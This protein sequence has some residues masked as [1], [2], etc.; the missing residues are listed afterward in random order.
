MFFGSLRANPSAVRQQAAAALGAGEGEAV[1]GSAIDRSVYDEFVL[2]L[3]NQ[4][5]LGGRAVFSE[6]PRVLIGRTVVT[7]QHN[8]VARGLYLFAME[9]TYE[10]SRAVHLLIWASTA[11]DFPNQVF[12]RYLRLLAITAPE[13][14]TEEHKV[15]VDKAELSSILWILDRGIVNPEIGWTEEPGI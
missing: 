14:F 1:G 3:R 5:Y 11:E 13:V 9:N 7:R 8:A 12:L 4:G 10:I 15:A 6:E 2:F